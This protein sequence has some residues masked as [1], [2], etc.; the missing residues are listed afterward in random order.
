[1]IGKKSIRLYRK[2]IETISDKVSVLC[3]SPVSRCSLLYRP[4]LK[5]L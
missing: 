5:L 1:M 4:D 3:V 2:D